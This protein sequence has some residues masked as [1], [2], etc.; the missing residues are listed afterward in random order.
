MTRAPDAQLR[1][2]EDTH[3]NGQSV[4]ERDSSPKSKSSLS[5]SLA[6]QSGG[7]SDDDGDNDA[8]KQSRPNLRAKIAE[9]GENAGKRLWKWGKYFRS[10]LHGGYISR[11]K[12]LVMAVIFHVVYIMS[13]FDTYF[14]SPI[15]N[16]MEPHTV[17]YTAG[18]APARR[19]V[20][21]IG[22]GLR[23]DKTFE[24]I[25][26][27]GPHPTTR[28]TSHDGE[29]GREVRQYAAPFLRSRVLEQGTFGVSHTGVPTESRVGN[30][31]LFGGVH[32]DVSAIR[33]GWEINPVDFDTIFKGCNRAWSWGD[34]TTIGT[35]AD[36]LKGKV[37]V[38]A[39]ND[40]DKFIGMDYSKGD[41]VA[42]DH[43]VVDRVEE[44]LEQ[45][46]TNSTLNEAL[47]DDKL[48]FFLHLEGI[49][50]RG[51]SDRPA[52]PAYT[53]HILEV[54]DRLRKLYEKIETF[55][56]DNATAY[57]F[58]ADHGMTDLG[59][60]GDGHPDN[61]RTPLVVWGAGVAPPVLKSVA[62]FPC[63]AGGEGGCAAAGHEDGYSKNWGLSHVARHDVQQVDIATLSAYLMGLRLP[64]NS[65][66]KLPL[67]FMDADDEQKALAALANAKQLVEMH[68]V[69]EAKM[70]H[71][72]GWRY[73]PYTHTPLSARFK[74][75]EE[76]IGRGEFIDS[77]RESE[78]VHKDALAALRYL[79][80][81]NWLLL[82][83]LVTA[84][85]LGWVAFA[86]TALVE[87]HI[88]TN[89][90]SKLPL[91]PPQRSRASVLTAFT[92]LA[93]L[94]I[95]F[96]STDS[97]GSYYLYAFFPVYLWEEAFARRRNLTTGLEAL[98][99]PPPTTA[100]STYLEDRGKGRSR[101]GRSRL[102]T[103]RFSTL[104][105]VT[106]FIALLE[107]LVQSYY[108]RWVYT[109]IYLL[110]AVYP[111]VY[112]LGFVSVHKGLVLCWL[113]GC[114][115]LSV[116]TAFLAP[117]KVQD[118]KAITWGGG[119]LTMV[120]LAYLAASQGMG[121]SANCELMKRRTRFALDYMLDGV[122]HLATAPFFFRS[123]AS[124]NGSFEIIEGQAE[125]TNKKSGRQKSKS[126][127]PDTTF[128]GSRTLQ[129]SRS[130]RSYMLISL[131][132][133]LVLVSL[134]VTRRTIKVLE[135]KEGLPTSHQY[136]N[137]AVF[138][139]ALLS[140]LLH[141]V[142]GDRDARDRTVS[143]FLGLA[144]AFTILGTSYEGLFYCALGVTLLLWIYLEQAIDTF[145]QTVS[146]PSKVTNKDGSDRMLMQT[147]SLSASDFRRGF[148]FFFL[149]N[150]AFFSTGN[151]ASASNF[152]LDAVIRL[153]PHLNYVY[154]GLLLIFKILAPMVLVSVAALVVGARVGLPPSALTMVVMTICDYLV[155]RFFWQVRV[156]GSWLEI[157]TTL[158][159]FCIG[160]L[161]SIFVA[162]LEL[163]AILLLAN[164]DL[165]TQTEGFHNAAKGRKASTSNL[166]AKTKAKAQNDNF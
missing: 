5:K 93:L 88:L 134:I 29:E 159:H 39:Y 99:N 36:G 33:N 24:A 135:A 90:H 129:S 101:S 45:A 66:G 112:G 124:A 63:L 120:G 77:I 67:D 30:A 165:H 48:L 86:A 148:F 32:E 108:H 153:L 50:I 149:V 53:K 61:T 158:S 9:K 27:P 38:H 160:S 118:E 23:A 74:G 51:H 147:R 43:W 42:L 128:E 156:E 146:G 151:V 139:A 73:Q 114:A 166:R 115:T 97:P 62:D 109:A 113:G 91:T 103:Y 119:C 150:S 130:S 34:V 17:L 64:M 131:Q 132:V 143:V 138:V 40:E 106:L 92:A 10:I 19:L 35:F 110:A 31:A 56:G 144:P 26:S 98:L 58:T 117:V 59:S 126:Q 140:P 122:R 100:G 20:F 154:Q 141:Q 1:R 80:T 7:T 79:Q 121:V 94:Y 22:D 11:G 82:R 162:C 47:H 57:L 21:I 18:H 105:K 65:V 54:D 136:L 107:A 13:I 87:C 123:A 127:T 44:L 6:S 8:Q 116:F 15:V 157:G 70:K 4:E 55:Y 102:G 46:R 3:Q 84:G 75:I 12:L 78:Q 95:H 137:W 2:R 164:C 37:T 52:S 71:E 89:Q 111:F 14:I 25:D 69:K 133:L 60:H 96:A 85:Y 49:D 104:L 28:S 72:R 68:R 81:Y 16:G 161:F 152:T 41:S 142:V 76:L 163:V 125:T 83:V 155:V 145:S